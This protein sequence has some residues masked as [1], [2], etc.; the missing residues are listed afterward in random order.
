[1]GVSSGDDHTAEETCAVEEQQGRAFKLAAKVCSSYCYAGQG[2][3]SADRTADAV[4]AWRLAPKPWH[5]PLPAVRRSLRM[6]LGDVL[7]K[8]T[9]ASLRKG[10]P[11]ESAS[12][13]APFVQDSVATVI[14]CSPPAGGV[15]ASRSNF[16]SRQR[17]WDLRTAGRVVGSAT[18]AELVGPPRS[19]AIRNN[20]K[21]AQFTFSA[22]L[23]TL[24]SRAGRLRSSV[25][26]SSQR[27]SHR[28]IISPL[29]DSTPSPPPLHSS[30]APSEGGEGVDWNR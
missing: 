23:N 22:G 25:L 4:A 26:V 28:P 6:T 3:R 29:D 13:L 10:I 21:M 15:A 9:K 30:G 2:G 7:A 20:G 8:A 19:I 24:F 11:K 16:E 5:G 1:L 27:L 18:G 17:S 14:S 12:A